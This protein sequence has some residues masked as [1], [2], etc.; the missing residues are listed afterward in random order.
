R[1]QTSLQSAVKL[2]CYEI[3]KLLIDAGA[4]VNMADAESN[5]L[6]IVACQNNH[7]DIAELLIQY[8]ADRDFQ[9]SDG[10]TA[11]NICGCDGNVTI[12]QSLL[13]MGC[14]VNI[15]NYKIQSPVYTACYYKHIEIVKLLVN[16]KDCDINWG[17]VTHCTPL[18][19]ACEV[20]CLKIV[21]LLL[22]AGKDLIFIQIKQ[23]SPVRSKAHHIQN[24]VYGQ[25]ILIR[26][27]RIK[28][29]CK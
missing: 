1:G 10:N 8:N 25:Q 29:G 5:S 22:Q 28:N 16:V 7:N 6:L 21:Q 19:L 20:G 23:I 11:L 12:T 13:N 26:F 14:D 17:D 24:S 2:G 9:N 27:Q 4:D 18:M 3:C 15:C